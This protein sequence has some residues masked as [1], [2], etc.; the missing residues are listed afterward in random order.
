[1]EP[2]LKTPKTPKTPRKANTATTLADAIPVSKG[3]GMTAGLEI[4]RLA[5]KFVLIDNSTDGRFADDV[6]TWNETVAGL[7]GSPTKKTKDAKK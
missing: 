4:R 3:A 1:M 7:N 2:K 6:A 5:D